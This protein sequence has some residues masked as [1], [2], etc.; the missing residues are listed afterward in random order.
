MAKPWRYSTSRGVPTV[1]LANIRSLRN[2]INGLDSC[3]K[4]LF[5]YKESCLLCFTETWLNSS[6]DDNCLAL[7]GFGLLLRLDRDS[8]NTGKST[9]GGICIHINSRW[10]NNI[11]ERERISSTNIELLSV[12]LWPF[13]LPREF[14]Q[15]FITLVYI[16][17]SANNKYA[18]DIIQ[19]HVDV[20]ENI[21]PESPK[22]ILGDFNGCSLKYTL[23]HYE[24]YVKCATRHSRTIDLCYGNV[25]NAYRALSASLPLVRRTTTVFT[26]SLSTDKS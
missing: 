10:C 17:P 21:S 5:E 16:P 14:G 9:G 15:I 6:V 12:S 23:P 11:T 13:Y 3:V 2:K 4:Y 26:L 8:D 24:Q 7:P 20:L 18:A 19:K 25:K 1:L 22:L